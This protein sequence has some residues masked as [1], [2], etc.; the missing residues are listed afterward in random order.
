MLLMLVLVLIGGIGTVWGC[1]HIRLMRVNLIVQYGIN[2]EVL[3][4]AAIAR[5]INVFI[6]IHLS[7]VWLLEHL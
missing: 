3:Y 1:K 4:L 2:P 5:R 7:H 6:R